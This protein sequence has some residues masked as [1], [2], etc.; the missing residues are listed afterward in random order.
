[1]GQKWEGGDV[2]RN[3]GGGQKIRLL[4]EAMEEFKNNE[5]LLIVFVDRLV[6]SA[7]VWVD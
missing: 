4:R 5:Y 6:S 7:S 2:A 1:M 3:P